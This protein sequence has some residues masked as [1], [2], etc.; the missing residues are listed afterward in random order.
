MEIGLVVNVKE[1]KYTVMSRDKY[2]GQNHN[3]NII[4]N[5][6]DG[7]GQFKYLRTTL[8]N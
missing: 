3:I 6:S 5:S 2:A 4:N 7:V 1:T 8:R